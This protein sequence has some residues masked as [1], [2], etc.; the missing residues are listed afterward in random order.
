[1]ALELVTGHGGSTHVDSE[2][3]GDF[4]AALFGK[5]CSVV[6]IGSMF[7]ASL[8]NANTVLLQGGN[9]MMYG[10]HVRLAPGD[11]QE[12]SIANGASG[13]HRH[14]LVCIR[15]EKSESTSVEGCTFVV[16]QGTPT[17]GTPVDPDYEA[18][19][20]LDG[21]GVSEMPLWRV[22][23]DG[24]TAS[25]ERVYVINR[26]IQD[27]FVY[28]TTKK[29]TG[30]TTDD[31][32]IIWGQVFRG[33]I[34]AAGKTEARTNLI[35]GLSSAARL[36]DMWGTWSYWTD[37]LQDVMLI[38]AGYGEPTYYGSGPIRSRAGRIDFSS[39]SFSQRTNAPYEAFVDWTDGT[40]R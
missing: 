26:R 19:S 6:D 1:M 5:D 13:Q 36:I 21:A 25:L 31:G 38:G 37:D 4:N 2:D 18:A 12:V 17:S 10:R 23:L 40:K 16:K 24:L 3:F 39:I 34:T 29:D 11:T 15:Y 8:I 32:Y 14:D 20:I 28:T 33:A 9:A 22:V 30:R 27:P 7:A 35:S